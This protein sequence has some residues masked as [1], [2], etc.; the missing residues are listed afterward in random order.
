MHACADVGVAGQGAKCAR[1]CRHMRGA[2]AGERVRVRF[3]CAALTFLLQKAY[4]CRTP[5]HAPYRARA[6]RRPRRL[7]VA[8]RWRRACRAHRKR[9][10]REQGGGASGNGVGSGCDVEMGGEGEYD[11]AMAREILGAPH[12]VG[13]TRRDCLPT[14]VRESPLASQRVLQRPLSRATRTSAAQ[15]P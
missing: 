6:R 15:L 3:A 14:A 10:T 13:R 8:M 4:A 2:D 5:K 9:R 1:G 11:E 7:L 12:N